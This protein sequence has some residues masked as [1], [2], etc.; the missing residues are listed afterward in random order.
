MK[1]WL[2]KF[3]WRVMARATPIAGTAAFLL[4]LAGLLA[5]N[6]G[7]S[8]PGDRVQYRT[9]LLTGS[10]LIPFGVIWRRYHEV[11]D[12]LNW[13]TGN[14]RWSVGMLRMHGLHLPPDQDVPPDTL[15]I[16]TSALAERWPWGSHHTEMLGH[17]D[18][19][20]RKWWANYDP[21]EPDTAPTNEMVADWLMEDRRVSRDKAKAIASILRADGLRSGPRR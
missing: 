8:L 1:V 13:L 11:N 20:A 15:G 12:R 10:L 6:A 7:W 3:S 5:L 19:A 16:G 9:L 4:G 21:G 2:P 17:V 18:A 14:L